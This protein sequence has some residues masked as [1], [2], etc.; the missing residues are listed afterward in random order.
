[1]VIPCGLTD[2]R[3]LSSAGVNVTG[4][5]STWRVVWRPVTSVIA[6]ARRGVLPMIRSRLVFWV[7]AKVSGCSGRC[8]GGWGQSAAQPQPAAMVVYA[9]VWRRQSWGPGSVL[10]GMDP[11]RPGASRQQ[12]SALGRG[13]RSRRREVGRPRLALMEVGRRFGGGSAP[14]VGRCLMLPEEVDTPHKLGTAFVQPASWPQ[15]P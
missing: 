7:V 14:V 6:P 2:N 12:P 15:C 3:T 13:A 1:M 10:E 5:I 8:G 4:C 9:R 11:W